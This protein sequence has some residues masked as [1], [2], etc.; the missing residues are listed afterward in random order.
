MQRLSIAFL[1][2]IAIL[3]TGCSKLFADV[4]GSV[5]GY[6]IGEGTAYWGGP[7]LL[8]TDSDMDCEQL[9]WVS[10]SNGGNSYDDGEDL[11]VDESFSA[12][13]FTYESAALQD[14]KLSIVGMPPSPAFAYFLVSDKGSI[15]VYK[16]V[17]GTIEIETN[18][19]DNVSGTFE[20]GFGDDG[21]LSGEF[22]I[23]NCA[24]LKPRHN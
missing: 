6:K 23:E 21:T 15:D 16:A 13:Q 5:A 1:L 10:Q 19:K 20:I 22:A 2:S 7:V 14:G 24:N 17:S 8:I 12:L 3:S 18:K 11:G 9:S 4:K